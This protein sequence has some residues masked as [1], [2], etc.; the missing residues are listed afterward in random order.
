MHFIRR[1]VS[2]KSARLAACVA[3]ALC[4]F[5]VAAQT[6]EPSTNDWK[7]EL[8]PYA[9][10]PSVSTNLKLGPLPG[11]ITHNS[12]SVLDALDFAAMASFEA[13]KGNWGG[14]LDIQYVKLGMPNRFAGGLPGGFTADFEDSMVNM[15]GFYRV[16]DAPV[17]FDL[18]GGA[19]YVHA[20]TD[21]T[22]APNLPGLERHLEDSVGWWN[23]VVGVRAIAPVAD[24]WSLMGYLDYGAGSSTSSWQGVAGVSYALSPAI[25]LKGGYRYLSLKRDEGLLN[26]LDLGGFYVGAG[27]KF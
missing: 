6:S 22:I 2:Q 13:R 23:G 17:S 14:L 8:V 25:S 21:V 19:R 18:L 10:L 5:P 4:G 1:I 24:K 16:M 7:Y 27:F 3:A 15:L 26:K 12:T 9:W 20:S 11:N